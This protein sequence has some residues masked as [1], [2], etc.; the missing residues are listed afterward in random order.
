[1]SRRGSETTATGV[2]AAPRRRPGGV[3]VAAATA[4]R[5]GTSNALPRAVRVGGARPAPTRRRSDATNTPPA[6][7]ANSS[8]AA[9]PA[10]LH[11]SI[12]TTTA[13][14]RL[15][16]LGRCQPYQRT[17]RRDGARG[18]GRQSLLVPGGA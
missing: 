8:N 12:P 1:M 10:L 14:N 5:R 16:E 7:A 2:E 9:A 6:D 13:C 4:T 11:R 3:S 18:D 17:Y 15:I